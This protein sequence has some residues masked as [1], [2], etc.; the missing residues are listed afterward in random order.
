MHKAPDPT[1]KEVWVSAGKNPGNPA[2]RL[3]HD[4]RREGKKRN[5]LTLVVERS[6]ESQTPTEDKRGRRRPGK[7]GKLWKVNPVRRGVE[8][9]RLG[10]R[11]RRLTVRAKTRSCGGGGPLE[12]KGGGRREKTAL[13]KGETKR[14]WVLAWG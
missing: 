2:K 1:E 8:K 3:K 6:A 14:G 12:E 11:R 13:E 7:K 10:G 4:N 5:T 9:R